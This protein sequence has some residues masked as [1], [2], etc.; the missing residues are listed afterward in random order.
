M[1]QMHVLCICFKKGSFECFF[2]RDETFLKKVPSRALPK[3]IINKKLKKTVFN[4]HFQLSIFNYQLF[5]PK[6]HTVPE[7]PKG[8]SFGGRFVHPEAVAVLMYSSAREGQ[9][10]R[11]LIKSEGFLP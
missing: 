11:Q 8:G 1:K 7:T 5:T 10:K 2:I 3:N 6:N 9:K 4:N